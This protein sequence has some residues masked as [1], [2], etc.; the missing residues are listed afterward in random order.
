M[1]TAECPDAFLSSDTPSV[2]TVTLKARS[3]TLTTLPVE[4]GE[5]SEAVA[6]S[7]KRRLH[8]SEDGS[9]LTLEL[10]N[11]IP[12]GAEPEV[13]RR[14]HVS[15][16]LMSVS[17]DI[18]MRNAC[19]FSSLSA[20]G[21]RIAG[22]IRRIGWIHPPKKGSGI[23]RPIHSDFVAVPENEVLYEES[24]PPLG[25]ILES[26]TKRFDWMVG[27]D[28]WRWTNAGRLGGFSRFTVTKENGGILFQWKLFDL[29]PDMEALPGRNWR[30]T[31]AAAWKPL[32]LSER[33]TPGKS[34]DLTVCN[35][36]TPTLASSSVK[37]S[38]DDA[39][40]RGCLCAAA[41]LNI[42]KKW[43]RSNLDSV[44][45][46]DVFALNNVL[47]VYCVNAGHLDRARLVSLPHWDM[48][49]ILEFRRWANRLLSKRGA[50]LEVLAPEKSPLRGF[51][52]LG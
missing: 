35:W 18:V 27:D 51:M 34:Y 45:K 7:G 25:M 44:K 13:C 39:A 8:H 10:S 43:V 38:H 31:W 12:F 28:F 30:L 52:I 6:L 20:G 16:G 1:I 24:Y 29:K 26:E 9:E 47:P 5:L 42:L 15:N 4:V 11:T 48:M 49:S 2:E 19:A 21:L 17:M 50:S 33:K 14:I 41:T 46:G 23:T 36:P 32:A 22:D 40:E 3:F 37:K